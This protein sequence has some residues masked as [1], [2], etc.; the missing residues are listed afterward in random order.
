MLGIAGA[1]RVGK[2]TL[3]KAFADEHDMDYL[4]TE[5]GSVFEELGLDPAVTY[6][7]STRLKVQR[8]I[9][10]HVDKLY[11]A[12]EDRDNTITDRTPLDLL[13]YTYAEVAGD[14]ITEEQNAELKAYTADCL[15][16]L[17]RRFGMVMILQP[18][19][20]VIAAPGKASL[21]ESYIE[22]LN[23]LC[24][25]FMSD[26]RVKV[27]CAYIPRSCTDLQRRID[28]TY[29]TFESFF[30]A[31]ENEVLNELEHGNSVH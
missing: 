14:N 5:V 9:L 17:N 31:A 21:N 28:A 18:G 20:P 16:V 11:G 24:L 4:S 12:V 3:A 22:H 1:H 10:R 15:E 8:A 30:K 25:G 13:I 2:S 6:D 29:R 26:E 23:L 27:K 19:I 7:F